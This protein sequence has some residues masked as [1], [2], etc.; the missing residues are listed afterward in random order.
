MIRLKMILL[1]YLLTIP[2][3]FGFNV[4]SPFL[5]IEIC[6]AMLNLP[7]ERRHRRL[8]QKEF[9]QK[10]GLDLENMG[11]QATNTNALEMQALRRI[12]L[13]HL[14]GDIMSD[15]IDI[16]YV[17]WINNTL[18]F[19]SKWHLMNKLLKVKKVGG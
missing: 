17:D 19:S 12:P 11:L 13:H 1:S 2:A 9:F 18:Q 14:S 3:H 15:F 8:W 10:V 7:I 5:D 6:M 16:K 4:W